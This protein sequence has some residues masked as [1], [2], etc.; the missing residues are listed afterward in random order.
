MKAHFTGDA[1]KH[2]T[3]ENNQQKSVAIKPLFLE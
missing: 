3:A 2:A 1:D